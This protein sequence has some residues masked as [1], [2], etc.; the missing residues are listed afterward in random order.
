MAKIYVVFG[1]KSGFDAGMSLSNLNGTNGFALTGE[2]NDDG[3]ALCMCVVR[4]TA[5]TRGAKL[6]PAVTLIN[7]IDD[8]AKNLNIVS[9]CC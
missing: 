3:E 7:G 2:V 6:A 8:H 1:S 5:C 4:R 9:P